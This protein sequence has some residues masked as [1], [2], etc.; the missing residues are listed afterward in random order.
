MSL[1]TKNIMDYV[2]DF[3]I[4]AGEKEWD[5][6]F[7]LQEWKEKSKD[8]E[9]IVKEPTQQQKVSL[10]DV[11]EDT[12]GSGATYRDSDRNWLYR[13]FNDNETIVVLMDSPSHAG[14][15]KQQTVST[16]L[17]HTMVMVATICLI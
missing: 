2:K 6:D 1:T 5:T 15:I 9:T 14:M 11:K 8:I 13:K 16:K 7:M 3:I 17:Y 12:V 10:S 4:Q